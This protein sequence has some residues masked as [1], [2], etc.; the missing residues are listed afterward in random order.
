MTNPILREILNYFD[1][2]EEE[3]SKYNEL[4]KI[5]VDQNYLKTINENIEELKFKLQALED[6]LLMDAFADIRNLSNA[7][8]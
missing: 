1:L 5:G 2:I 3:Y 4:T 7:L 8:K 6:A